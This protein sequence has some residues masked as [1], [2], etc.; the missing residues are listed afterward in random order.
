MLT[1]EQVLKDFYKG[2]AKWVEEGCSVG[3][4]YRK[5]YG[6]CSNLLRYCNEVAYTGKYVVLDSMVKQF[7][8][9]G[10]NTRTPFNED[11][12]DY[13]IEKSYRTM[14]TNMARLAWIKDHA[15]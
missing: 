14:Y 2:I 7:E 8:N 10:L 15:Q 11:H 13:A 5:D 3:G 4:V 9:A 12:Y 1:D 6:L